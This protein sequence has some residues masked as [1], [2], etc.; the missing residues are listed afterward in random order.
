M[1]EPR[2]RD[3]DYWLL[4][5]SY[6]LTPEQIADFEAESFRERIE[7][8]WLACPYTAPKWVYL[9]WLAE[10][11]KLLFHGSN[12]DDIAR[13]EPRKPNDDSPDEFSKR[14]AVFA[15][16]APIWAMFYAL[17]D[18]SQVGLR[19]LNGAFQVREADTLSETHYFFSVT[20]TI[21]DQGAWRG[22]TL[23]LLSVETF[24]RQASYLWRGE[25]TLEHQW[26]SPATVDCVAKVRV[27]PHDFPFLD[28]VRGHDNAHVERR[29]AEEPYGFPWLE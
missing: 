24:E 22:G 2:L 4:Q 1:A 26:A 18:R 15:T 11:E 25:E 28:K 5:P 14:E 29:S 20:Q 16:S 8:G 6:T 13:L 19:I 7:N 17:V 3:G 12:K 23:Y 27:E 9:E 10:H 21:L